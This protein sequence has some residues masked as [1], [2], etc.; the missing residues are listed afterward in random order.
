MVPVI[1]PVAEVGSE[2]HFAANPM[3]TRNSTLC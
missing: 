2:R 3:K 1:R